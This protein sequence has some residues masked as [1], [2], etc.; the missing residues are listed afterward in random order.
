[1]C[2]PLIQFLAQWAWYLSSQVN[3]SHVWPLYLR[4]EWAWIVYYAMS[5]LTGPGVVC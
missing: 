5:H 3:F 4:Q 1:M 2:T